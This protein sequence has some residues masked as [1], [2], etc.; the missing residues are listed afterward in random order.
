MG[1]RNG[2]GPRWALVGDVTHLSVHVL[3][4]CERRAHLV[5]Q[6]LEALLYMH[7][8]VHMHVHMHMHMH[9][10]CTCTCTP[11]AH[12]HAHL[13]LMRDRAPQLVQRLPFQAIELATLAARQQPQHSSS[14]QC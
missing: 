10:F 2:M 5:A 8:H 9:T 11:S 4:A 12:A 6:R 14:S 13:L 7:M 3:L 1:H